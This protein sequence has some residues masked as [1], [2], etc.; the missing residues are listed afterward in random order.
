MNIDEARTLAEGLMREH[1]LTGWRLTFDHARTRAGVCRY[2]HREIGLSGVL[3]ELHSADLVRGTVL[4]EIA[5]ALVGSRHA[6]DDV[7]QAK[8]R[9]IGADGQRRMSASA[10]RPVAPWVGTCLWGHEVTR[11]RRP[12]RP[13]SCLACAPIFDVAHLIGWRFHGRDMP[14]SAAYQAELTDI[15][16]A[17]ERGQVLVARLGPVNDAVPTRL[18]LDGFLPPGTRVVLDGCG[19][20]AGL[21]G[22]IEKRGRTRYHV[23]TRIGTVTAPF[24]LVRVASG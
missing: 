5:H 23:R 22:Q 9:A 19:K 11:H 14:M 6:H 24:G 10:P 12:A 8:A 4:H 17:A 20:Y 2:I 3:A 7:W 16:T 21:S 1:H 15:R 18:P 13:S